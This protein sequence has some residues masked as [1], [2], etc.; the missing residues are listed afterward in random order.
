MANTSE[1]VRYT[2]YSKKDP[3]SKSYDVPSYEKDIR[4]IVNNAVKSALPKDAF[5]QV[6]DKSLSKSGRASWDIYVHNDDK[7]V[8]SKSLSKVEQELRFK[9]SPA[10]KYH[11]TKARPVDEEQVKLLRT[12]EKSM[13]TKT[14]P[15][16]QRSNRGVMLKLLAL[17]TTAVD[18]TRRIL[19]SVLDFSTRTVKDMTTAHNYGMSYEAVRSYRHIETQ[20]GL[21]EGTITGAVSDIQNKFGNITSLDEKAL[22]AL[23]VVMGGKIEEMATMGLGAS[24]PEAV[25]GAILDAFNEKANAGYNSVGQYVGEQQARRELYSY[26][27]K[28]SPQVADIFATMQ[29]EQHNINS[30]FRNQFETF[31]EWRDLRPTQRGGNNLS[32]YNV[33]VT[34]GQEW[35]QVKEILSQIREK[36]ETS[37]APAVLNLLRVI[38]NNRFGLTTGENMELN[39]KNREE[40]QAEIERVKSLLASSPEPANK[41][42]TYYLKSLRVYL[43]ELE[44]ANKGDRKGNIASAVRTPEE[45]RVMAN[46][47]AWSEIGGTPSVSMEYNLSKIVGTPEVTTEGIL[48][49]LEG[50]GKFD[51]DKERDKYQKKLDTANANIYKANKRISDKAEEEANKEIKKIEQENT[52]KLIKESAIKA[53]KAIENESSVYFV[54]FRK[55]FKSGLLNK[56]TTLAQAEQ[57]FGAL[58]G[59]T[60]ADKLAYALDKGYVVEEYNKY[61]TFTGYGVNRNKVDEISKLGILEQTAIRQEAQLRAVGKQEALQYNEDDFLYWLYNNN[62]AWFNENLG[63]LEIERIKTESE[64]GNR[65]ASLFMLYNNEKNW[66]PNLPD[67]YEGTGELYGLNVQGNGGETTHKIILEFGIGANKQQVEV[68]SFMGMES[69]EGYLGKFMFT[70]NED[71]TVDYSVS[72]ADTASETKNTSK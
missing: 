21:K 40:N 48:K 5:F 25:L 72:L 64:K 24:N 3:S 63:K 34:T 37:F 35:N 46:S 49:V 53:E 4:N 59:K 56:N 39:K 16:Y 2:V 52:E 43:E 54:P 69:Y 19:S 50:Y 12:L 9:G 28:I 66:L 42:E 70:K 13:N 27:L 44:K 11:I 61:G 10:E 71:G 6:S 30:I 41:A 62:Q 18:I 26:L 51:L 68:G 32:D 65:L 20:H 36:F 67:L 29:E 14:E 33:V 7:S 45:L 38:S 17:L 23:A 1:Y 60:V 47:L 15:E 58:K 31:D 22:E 8:M 57:I 55:R